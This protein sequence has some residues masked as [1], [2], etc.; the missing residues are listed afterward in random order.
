MDDQA[1]IPQSTL[2][3]LF[4]AS[5]WPHWTDLNQELLNKDTGSAETFA[6]SAEEMEKYFLDKQRLNLP[7]DNLLNLFNAEDEPALQLRRMA[8]FLK[9][10]IAL[11]KNAGSSAT[12]LIIYYV[13]H[14][15]F[16]DGDF[17]L[18]IR[19]SEK[20]NRIASS[21]RPESLVEIIK[22]NARDLSCF[23]LI[24]CCFAGATVSAFDDAPI[25]GVS[26]LCSSASNETS[27]ATRGEPY[28]M[29]S[30]ILLQV[31]KDGNREG[32]RWF[33]LRMLGKEIR[34]EIDRKYP[35]N[36]VKPIVLSPVQRACD[37]A[38][39]PMFPNAGRQTLKED[40]WF[41]A[42]SDLAQCYVV[43]SATEEQLPQNEALRIL[44]QS[45]LVKYEERLSNM[46][47]KKL[48]KTPIGVNVDRVMASPD[49]LEN[50]IEALCQADIAVFDVTNYEPVVML[51][52]GVRSV[53]RRGVT[54][55]SAGG[56]YVIGDPIQYPF[57]IKEVNIVSHSRKQAKTYNP[58]DLIGT[59]MIAGFEQLRYLP[60]YLDLPVFD[61]IRT[62]PPEREQRVPKAC[63]EQVLMLCPFSRRYT[64]N[65]WEVHLKPQLEVHLPKTQAGESPPIIRTLDIK[66]PRLVSQSLYEEMR[67]TQMCVVDWT[68]WRPT[69]FFELGVR[70]AGVDIDP[71]CIIETTQKQLIEDLADIEDWNESLSTLRA[72]LGA[73]PK[74]NKDDGQ[75][76]YTPDD[77]E[78]FAYS[79]YQ[80]RR[81]FELFNPFEYKAPKQGRIEA[82][83]LEV[84]E[85]IVS[86]H[87]QLI[88]GDDSSGYRKCLPPGFTYQIVSAHIDVSMEVSDL[89][90]HGELMRAADLL[91]DPQI[92]SA[93]RS[94]V[95]YPNN[96][97]LTGRA[98]EGALERRLAAW[99]YI[100][101]RLKDKLEEDPKLRKKF[102]DLGN[103]IARAL[104][105]S[106]KE[107]AKQIRQR[108]KELEGK[109]KR[110]DKP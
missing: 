38:D 63:N 65:N 60:N 11:L 6:A 5:N 25:N 49:G 93:G 37:I 105:R 78:R 98:N 88:Q 30:G 61:A 35:E 4:G 82:K 73:D 56:D 57:S 42:K 55:A 41:A 91:S 70:L 28:T 109:I 32:P 16:V 89:P 52:L 20:D 71:V 54:I 58:I 33:S 103:L 97:S 84:Y 74:V 66:S 94:P 18:V 51:L 68:D 31:L 85:K 80:C 2:V 3:V 96:E 106:D 48:D 67:L 92:D 107:M 21:L 59:K 87:L 75:Q 62:L 1:P 13:G 45:A 101:N 34:Q 17:Y 40:E 44:V 47:G 69:V 108:I 36:G 79:A 100:D 95:L 27:R 64:D 24:D 7:A 76:N 14:G 15:G 86:Y 53:V 50:A 110:E 90:V 12:H 43:E 46:I 99:Y 8:R 104:L 77:L 26:L 102:I 10:R 39:S 29:F 83:D 72:Q 19:N 9:N 22:E 23:L 81:M